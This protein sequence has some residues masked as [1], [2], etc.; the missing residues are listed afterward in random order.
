MNI[1]TVQ[2]PETGCE[3]QNSGCGKNGFIICLLIAKNEEGSNIHMVE[4]Y[5][6]IAHGTSILK[7]L[8]LLGLTLRKVLVVIVFSFCF[9]CR[10]DI[11]YW[12][13]VYWSCED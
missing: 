1:A 13:T 7:Y 2:N 4:N 6:G 5:E 3:I 9:K 12:H 11:M 8:V 10:E